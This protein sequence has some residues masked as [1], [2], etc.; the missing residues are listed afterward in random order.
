MS[1]VSCDTADTRILTQTQ[2]LSIAF[3]WFAGIFAAMQFAKFSISYEY[4]LTAYQIDGASAG[5]LLSVVGMVGLVLGVIGGV[6]SGKIGYSRVLIGSLLIGGGL[7]LL[8]SSLPSYPVLLMSRFIEGASHLGVVIAAPTLMLQQAQKK[9][10]SLVMGIWGAFFGVAFAITG[11]LGNQILSVYG[12]SGLFLG[13][14]LLSIPLIV[15]FVLHHPRNQSGAES[16]IGSLYA[17]FQT[18]IRVY[19]NPR[20]CFPGV[21]FF[22]HTF[23]FVALLTFI[24]RTSANEEI[25][26]LLFVV[27]PLVSILGTFLAGALTQYSLK[28]PVLLFVAYIAIALAT[29]ST[30]KLQHQ[31]FYFVAAAVVLMLFSGMVQGASFTLIPYLSQTESERAM[32]NGA[33]AQLGNLGATI[34]PPVF[35]Y[36]IDSFEGNGLFGITAALCVAGCITAVFIWRFND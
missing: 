10:H 31:E 21:V 27:L 36:A 18:T 12:L 2:W 8:Q 14:A 35:A 9:H 24:P 15:F 33:I 25:R 32:G 22:F 4:L 23:M 17:L 29:F 20:T 5:T 34:G 1:S 7:S 30:I 3:L 26:S 28:A 13:H 19:L 11:W 6:L 16:G